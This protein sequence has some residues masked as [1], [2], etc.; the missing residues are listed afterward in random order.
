M[1][2]GRA[3]DSPDGAKPNLEA[4]EAAPAEPLDPLAYMLQVMNDPRAPPE[5]RD[6]MAIAAAPFVH[7]R[8]TEA[9]KGKKAM[10]QL[11]AHTAHAGSGWEE[12]LP[13]WP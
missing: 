7:P 11:E 4:Q 6:R 13:Q 5:R 3:P 12:L 2:S 9:A 10:Q 8:V 1:A